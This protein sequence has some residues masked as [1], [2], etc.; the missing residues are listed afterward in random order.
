MVWPAW[1]WIGTPFKFSL[2]LTNR[3][4]SGGGVWYLWWRWRA[5]RFFWLW[6]ILINVVS[7]GGLILLFFWLR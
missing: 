5:K 7:W 6:V 2:W 4:A 3:L 1:L